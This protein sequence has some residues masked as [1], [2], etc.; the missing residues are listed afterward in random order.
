MLKRFLCILILS[1]WVT[2][3]VFAQLL[4]GESVSLDGEPEM[5]RT[6]KVVSIDQDPR[7]EQIAKRLREILEVTGWVKGQVVTVRRG[8][9]NLKGE[10]DRKSQSEWAERLAHDTEGVVA[11]TND[12]TVTPRGWL[13][14]T[15]M[16]TESEGLAKKI[17]EFL[18]Y[19]FS[20]V[21]V[22]VIFTAIASIATKMGRRAAK[23]RMQN[24]LMIEI[25]A[26]LAGLP[27]VLLGLYLALRLSGL[28][29]VAITI[30]GGTG[31]MGLVVGFALKN[32]LE[33]YFSGVMLSLRNPYTVGDT[34][35]I[36]GR[37]GVVQKLTTRGTILVDYDGNHIIIP[38]SA[39]YN[40]MIVNISATPSSRI[41]FNFT[42]LYTEDIAVVHKLVMH[43]VCQVEGVL[44][45]PS[46]TVVTDEFRDSGVRI[47]VYFW[48][49][50]RKSSLMKM[51]SIVMTAVQQ[52][53]QKAEVKFAGAPIQF[54]MPA[55]EAKSNK[56][57]AAQ[58]V[59]AEEVESNKSTRAEAAELLRHAESGRQ[60][61][62]GDR[63]I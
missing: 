24:P 58:V 21:V 11:V 43:T 55:P 47:S 16:R 42:V 51:K 27:V 17:L 56:P 23:R 60:I 14:L 13:D 28:S 50:P 41:K 3:P 49:D 59:S 62:H 32:I 38:N 20:A 46:P 22:L 57:N 45:D 29:G 63:L 40:G 53:L 4:Q 5:R 15:P 12:I 10:V 35:E 61:D 19:L 2:T 37:Q 9:V 34:V 39:I 36:N 30:L 8:V 1:L 44:R 48:V 33:N 52:C 31:A 7:D 25:L 54:V 6:S 26:R 18:P